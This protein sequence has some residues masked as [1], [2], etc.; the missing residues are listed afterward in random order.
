[1]AAFAKRLPTYLSA[2]L[3]ARL[4]ILLGSLL[5][6]PGLVAWI[7]SAY[8]AE[9]VLLE[10]VPARRALSRSAWLSRT[11][12][13]DALGTL[14]ALLVMTIGIVFAAE[15]MGLA[16]VE[17]VLSIPIH[18]SSVFTKGGSYFALAGYFA[19]IPWAA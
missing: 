8:V 5:V 15:R 13:D 7:R 4:L 10:Q 2:I 18:P 11:G 17:D 9:A 14:A 12:S 16:I 6:V 19:S 1:L 3:T